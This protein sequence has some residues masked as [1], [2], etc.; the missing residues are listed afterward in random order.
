LL[1]VLDSGMV[2]IL[3]ASADIFGVVFTI[4]PVMVRISIF[5][6]ADSLSI[7]SILVPGNLLRISVAGRQSVN[8]GWVLRGDDFTMNVLVSPVE[9]NW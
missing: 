3:P 6:W 4:V 7:M 2:I 9:L 5:T 1:R 8:N